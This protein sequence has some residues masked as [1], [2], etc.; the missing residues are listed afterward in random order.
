VFVKHFELPERRPQSISRQRLETR[1]A[2]LPTDGGVYGVTYKWNDEEPMPSCCPAA[3]ARTSR[4]PRPTRAPELNLGHTQRE[5]CLVC[6][7]RQAGYVL[8]VNARQLNGDYTIRQRR[9]GDARRQD[10][11]SRTISASPNAA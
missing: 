3:C 8:G 11:E 5:N 10:R 4:S 2:R 6:H 7:N 9:R 1:F